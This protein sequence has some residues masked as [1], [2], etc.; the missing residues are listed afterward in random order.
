MPDTYPRCHE[1]FHADSDSVENVGQEIKVIF[2]DN[3]VLVNHI[4][5]FLYEG[6]VLPYP[7][8]GDIGSG[9]M[10]KA[11]GAIHGD[12]ERCEQCQRGDTCYE[13]THAGF[14]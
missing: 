14:C 7:A 10:Q 6:H 5:G 12:R 13:I 9:M 4:H 3:I 11:L 2:G 8:C 1:R